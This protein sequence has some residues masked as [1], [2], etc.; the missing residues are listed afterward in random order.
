M[1]E[2]I[3]AQAR[4]HYSGREL[5]FPRREPKLDASTTYQDYR[6]WPLPE[7][8]LPR[9]HPAMANPTPFD[10]TTTNKSDFVVRGWELGS[11]VSIIFLRNRGGGGVV[12]MGQTVSW[13]GFRSVCSP[14]VLWSAPRLGNESVMLV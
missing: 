12:A 9:E 13:G 3:S 10:G 11:R 7:R 6:A 14:R 1:W 4:K 2:A 8:S 5:V